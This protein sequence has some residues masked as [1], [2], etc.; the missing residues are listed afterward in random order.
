MGRTKASVE[1]AGRLL[2]L[3]VWKVHGNWL[4]E[5]WYLCQSS[6]SLTVIPLT[7]AAMADSNTKDGPTSRTRMKAF[8]RKRAT[9][10]RRGMA[11]A[12]ILHASWVFLLVASQV[13]LMFPN[14]LLPCS[15]LSASSLCQSAFRLT[16]HH[17]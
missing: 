1:V 6:S 13:S 8:A 5:S 7:V 2:P 10:T 4:Q 9:L 16:S 3:E 17:S 14:L 15:Q 12:H 11:A